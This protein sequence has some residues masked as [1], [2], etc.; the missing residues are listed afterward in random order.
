MATQTSLVAKITAKSAALAEPV[1]AICQ[2][3]P[4]DSAK[5]QSEL[6]DLRLATARAGAELINFQADPDL[7][8]ALANALPEYTSESLYQSRS[9]LLSLGVAVF[10]GWLLGGFLDTLLNLAGLG[11]EILRPAAILGAIWLEE[12]LGINPRARR[13]MLTVLGLGALGR[14]AASLA[15]GVVR[16][17]SLGSLIFR[18]GAKPGFFK[19]A[20]LWL[21]AI[22]L[23]V[24][25]AR[26][27]TGLNIIGFREDLLTQINQRLKLT[28]L[29]LQIIKDKT[30]ELDKIKDQLA[31]APKSDLCPKTDCQ[32]ALA[33]L[34]M[35]N[36]FTPDQRRYLSDCLT[37]AGYAPKGQ[38]SGYLVWNQVEY[39]DLYEPLGLIKD[40]DRCLV[41]QAP[42]Q[43]GKEIIKGVV[44]RAQEL[45]R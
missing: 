28:C 44:Q 45:K 8:L 36:S 1:L 19:S 40:G 2:T 11:G 17:S 29:V 20:W 13:I 42:Y 16:F 31:R 27:T 33:T 38:D 35:L 4:S 26:K 9:S 14:L 34:S 12:Y 3:S 18:Q 32:L 41:L 43:E 37:L 6:Y 30:S 21:G 24:F 39:G 23:Y 22:F 7:V 25:F 5:L 15:A 10:L